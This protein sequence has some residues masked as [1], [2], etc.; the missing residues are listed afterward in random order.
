MQTR[1]VEN[2]KVKR[3]KSYCNMRQSEIWGLGRGAVIGRI[4]VT[5]L[6][7]DSVLSEG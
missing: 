7:C 1:A 4:R 5:V 2:G 3:G 6:S